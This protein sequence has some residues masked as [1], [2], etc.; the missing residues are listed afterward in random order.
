M[1][2]NAFA[3]GPGSAGL[4]VQPISVTVLTPNPM[5]Y[6]KVNFGQKF[7]PPSLRTKGFSPQTEPMEGSMFNPYS[8]PAAIQITA[9]MFNRFDYDQQFFLGYTLSPFGSRQGL[10]E[11]FNNPCPAFLYL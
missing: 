5:L 10:T 8:K 11:T 1:L 7:E 6:W 3:L 9:E 4:S 2:F